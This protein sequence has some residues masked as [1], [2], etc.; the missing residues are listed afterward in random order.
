MR[1]WV[2]IL[3]GLLLVV[4]CGDDDSS[5]FGTVEAPEVCTTDTKKEY[6]W[7]VLND[8][9]YW[10]EEMPS[11]INFDEYDDEEDLLA[12]LRYST[13]DQYS[14]IRTAEEEEAT[15][16]NSSVA[17]GISLYLNDDEN[18]Y[19]VRYAYEDSPAWKAG[20]RR[21]HQIVSFEGVSVADIVV[22]I[23][24]G[25]TTWTD[26]VGE[27]EVGVARIIN[28]YDT[29]GSLHS[30]EIEKA[31]IDTNRVHGETYYDTAVGTVGYFAFTSFTEASADELTEVFES[32]SENNADELILDLRYNTGG[33][34][35]V[36]KQLG[37]LIGGVETYNQVFV[38]YEHNDTYSS[39]NSSKYFSN[40][41]KALDLDSVIVLT[42]EYSCSASEL[43]INTLDPFIDVYVIGET[44]CG[45]PIGM[46]S[47]EYCD[48]YL[49]PI[50]FKMVNSEGY[51]DYF[52][53]W[54]PDCAVED[55]PQYPYGDERDTQT[56]AALAYLTSGT[57]SESVELVVDK[58]SLNS[59]VVLYPEWD[60]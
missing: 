43:V 48:N 56:A 29:D 21:G 54:T 60:N 45:K 42:D 32:L 50:E 3:L 34:I 24:A 28:W 4:G 15:Q 46:Y 26:V 12:S 59:P 2:S 17:W 53:G 13:T 8:S 11:S 57:C 19:I 55:D 23:S 14:F 33:R 38:S 10:A 30:E 6:V 27:S 51:G 47:H 16:S 37:S 49:Y 36:A 39:S 9:Y 7:E 40:L 31:E 20:M 22:A 44:T 35:S 1:S 58:E 5:N 25:E 52:D 18:A 41:S